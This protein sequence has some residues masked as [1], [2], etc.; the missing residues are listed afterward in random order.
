MEN[1]PVYSEQNTGYLVVKTGDKL[2]PFAVVYRHFYGYW[3]IISRSS[4]VEVAMDL[5]NIYNPTTGPN[6]R[7]FG[8]TI[9]TRESDYKYTAVY[10]GGA[11]SS[12]NDWAVHCAYPGNKFVDVPAINQL[13]FL[14]N[15]CISAE[16][17]AGLLNEIGAILYRPVP[18]TCES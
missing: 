14:T 18:Q 11:Y 12:P 4:R 15:G 13:V 2:L 3:E 1:T 17:I 5:F 8:M 10:S 6:A 7:L 9:P 16:W